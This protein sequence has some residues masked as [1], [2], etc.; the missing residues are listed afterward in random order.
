MYSIY[1]FKETVISFLLRMKDVWQI[2]N[3]YKLKYL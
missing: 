3:L 2:I 1:M